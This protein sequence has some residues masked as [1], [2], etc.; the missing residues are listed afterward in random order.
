M[1]HQ[2]TFH[3]FMQDPETFKVMVERFLEMPRLPGEL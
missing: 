3:R 2:L 1:R